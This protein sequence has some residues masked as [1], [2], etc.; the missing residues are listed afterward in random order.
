[1]NDPQISQPT[2][3]LA[4]AAAVEYLLTR[5]SRDAVNF[6][7]KTASPREDHQDTALVNALADE[8]RLPSVATVANTLFP[9]QLA[10]K[11]LDS[12]ALATR[13]RHIVPRLRRLGNRH[14][15][16]FARIVAFGSAS[17]PIDQLTGVITKLR[18]AR[19]STIGVMSSRYELAIYDPTL[20]RNKTRGFP[21]LSFLSFHLHENA[22]HL[23]AHYRNHYYVERAY[24]NYVALGALL[25]YVAE[26]A[27]WAP[28]ELLV[29]SGRATLE[30]G[31]PQRLLKLVSDLRARP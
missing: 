12:T 16:Y 29:V 26:Q 11:S 25:T 18:A 27:S 5:P 23:A 2:I 17:D 22:L 21:C 8:R 9:R 7:V 30:V 13:Y 1:M 20:D 10:A 31:S 19:N 15:T 3:G 14:G 4:W 28:G 24:G 6:A